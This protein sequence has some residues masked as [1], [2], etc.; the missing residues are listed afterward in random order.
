MK[1][2]FISL[3]V[4]VSCFNLFSEQFSLGER[5][6]AYHKGKGN[7]NLI[8][9]VNKK[10]TSPF[11]K[12]LS[13]LF[14]FLEDSSIHLP[15]DKKIYLIL[16]T[17]NSL[18]SQKS[19][20]VYW[21]RNFAT[22]DW[23]RKDF[24]YSKIL[25]CG[26]SPGSAPETKALTSFFEQNLKEQ[27]NIVLFLD[28]TYPCAYVSDFSYYNQNLANFIKKRFPEKRIKPIIGAK[29]TMEGW[30]AENLKTPMLRMP[31]SWV[32]QDMDLEF[33]WDLLKL[34][35]NSKIFKKN[36]ISAE[37]FLLEMLFSTLPSDVTVEK[38]KRSDFYKL[39]QEVLLNQELVLLI[40]K[41]NFLAS[42]Y[43]PSDLTCI[44]SL[45]FSH[46]TS[47]FFRAAALPALKNLFTDAFT[48]EI[49]LSIVSSYRSYE[50]QQTV[51]AYWTKQ[52][53]KKE[54]ERIS[55]Y[56][57]AS[58]HQLGTAIDFN[59]LDE[60]FSE[61]KEG[62]WLSRNAHRYGF[63]LSYPKDMEEFTGYKYEPWHYRYI[64]NAAAK[65]VVEYFNNNLELFLQWLW[66]LNTL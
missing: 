38:E 44:D 27:Q 17:E 28:D 54:A 55:A 60:T 3:F 50:T 22:S 29:G 45:R 33:L 53:G 5:I 26:N 15:Q 59:M 52:F 2:F 66:S 63:V 25:F 20:P 30:L 32:E 7:N 48:D 6:V 51:F 37:A 31:L 56:P 40:N 64:G 8:F 46:K 49:K 39:L 23:Q 62:K 47:L 14:S 36:T 61:T 16:G 24:Y 65:L 18:I 21:Q 34:D 9:I 10:M 57:G 12:V 41:K 19:E 43:V 11:P 13:S 35:F 1:R 58:Q 4:L 42:T